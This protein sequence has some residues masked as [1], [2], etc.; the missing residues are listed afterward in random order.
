LSLDTLS[1]YIHLP[2]CQRKCA[3]CDFN[4]YAGLDHLFIPYV[5]A[6]VAEIAIAGQRWHHPPVETVY[7]GGGTPTLLS[8]DLLGDILVAC[9]QTFAVHPDAEITCEANPGTVDRQRFADLRCLGVNRLSLGVQ[10]FEDDE[11]RLLGRVHTVEEAE[12][13]FHAAR[14]VGFANINLD[15]IFGLPRQRRGTWRRTLCRAIA[16]A[17]EHLSL[18][19]LSIEEGTPLAREVAEGHVPP[20]DDDL[21]ADFYLIA[22]DELAGAGYV[23]YEIS[24]WA[25][26]EV[27]EPGGAGVS[28]GFSCRHNLT[29]W[30]N[31]SYLGFGAGAHSS[32]DGRRW[33]NVRVPAEYIERL[34]KVQCP[35]AG[36][37][38]IDEP[39]VMAE[40]MMLGLRLV[41]E[42]V[43]YDAFE[44]RFGHSL[45]HMYGGEI[46]ALEAAG[47]LERLPDRIR[48]SKRGRLLGNQVFVRFLPS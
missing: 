23:H 9:R 46:A 16:L 38:K 30:H 43:P 13:A 39:L 44:R 21:A 5:R 32:L 42:G 20:P 6:L 48:I 28:P 40:A 27:D 31:G 29:Y 8:P 47:L 10:S 45:L 12:A 2:F 4:S 11:L 7:L 1:L 3:Y 34:E 15:L 19:A 33:W 17:P 26:N 14:A 24:N 41:Q 37:E 25:R 35:V 18:Y 36:S 22:S